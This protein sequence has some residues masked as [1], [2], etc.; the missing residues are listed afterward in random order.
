MPSSGGRIYVFK[1]NGKTSC[2]LIMKGWYCG[3]FTHMFDG[4]IILNHS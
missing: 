2:Q 4:F 1:K 3:A